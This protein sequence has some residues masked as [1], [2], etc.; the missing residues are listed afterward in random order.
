MGKLGEIN[1]GLLNQLNQLDYYQQS[2]PK[3]LGREWMEEIFFPVLEKHNISDFDKMRTLY[4][5]IAI[6][7]SK[8][9]SKNGKLLITGGGAFNT[10]LIERI[11][12]HSTLEV[13]IPEPDI[14]N[15][16]EALVFAFLGVLRIQNKTNCYASVTGAIKD[17]SCGIVFF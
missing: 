17:S 1:N 8:L 2:P 5:D 9:N 11:K 6:Q 16:K 3:S 15:F 12:H 4:E 13:I 10:F 7:I 14:I